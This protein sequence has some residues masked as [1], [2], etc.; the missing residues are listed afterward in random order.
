[1]QPPP[2]LS[3]KEKE[4]RPSMTA[5]QAPDPCSTTICIANIPDALT[6]REF[7]LMFKFAWGFERSTITRSKETGHQIGYA[8]FATREQADCAIQVLNGGTIDEDFDRT[9]KCF[10]SSTQ[11]KDELVE[12]KLQNTR[13]PFP[14]PPG[15][16]YPVPLRIGLQGSRASAPPTPAKAHTSSIY[17]GGI[18]HEWTE[19]MLTQLFSPYGNITHL[20]LH[21]G[22]NPIGKV[23]FIFFSLPSESQA[24]I[25]GVNGLTID[26][27]RYLTVRANTSTQKGSTTQQPKVSAIGRLEQLRAS[28]LITQEEYLAKKAAIGA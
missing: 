20:S 21:K 22:N 6:E 11:L 27:T 4:K 3:S 24:A 19:E 28:G 1:M 7:R 18:P 23:A 8:R 25:Q 10:L 14:L 17:V 2:K 16:F 5:Q 12:N 9:A 13:F 15:S 26:G